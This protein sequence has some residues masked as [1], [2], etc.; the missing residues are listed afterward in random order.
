[1]FGTQVNQII[2]ARKKNADANDLFFQVKRTGK[3]EEMAEAFKRV[4]DFDPSW[5]TAQYHYGI[6]LIRLAKHKEALDNFQVCATAH[7]KW[8]AA[9]YHL[10]LCHLKTGNAL[11]AMPIFKS[12]LDLDFRDDIE[13]YSKNFETLGDQYFIMARAEKNKALRDNVILELKSICESEIK[14]NGK[15][16]WSLLYI[17]AIEFYFGKISDSLQTF[18]LASDIADHMAMNQPLMFRTAYG[19]YSIK[20]LSS[21]T[22]ILEGSPRVPAP[23]ITLN[24]AAPRDLVFLIGCDDGYFNRF[25]SSFLGTLYET[26]DNITVHF[27]I[28]GDESS[29]R[30]QR[31]LLA[32]TLR[33]DRKISIE[34]SFEAKPAHG[35]KTYYAL[36]RFVIASQIMNHYQCD[37]IIGDID[38][39]VIGDLHLVKSHVGDSDVGV[40]KNSDPEAFRKFPWNAIS[41]CYL[42]I[43][44]TPKGLDYARVISLLMLETFNPS[45]PKTWWLD[46]S[47][48]YCAT[49]YMENLSFGFK[50]KSL[51][52][53]K[54]PKPFMYSIPGKSKDDF[55]KSLVTMISSGEF[56]KKY[57]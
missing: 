48:L 16:P 20:S 36:S 9:V 6:A 25:S 41:G 34:F 2:E 27:H 51:I 52:G 8:I 22:A 29:I 39:A 28:I 23:V 1:M 11:M 17:A 4:V 32:S 56:Q 45:S 35:N 53:N 40:D 18:E 38:A 33:K 49:Y 13:E 42:Y 3:K 37:L 31:D 57:A 10:G 7:P 5:T 30:V 46:Q 47:V 54:A 26:N 14:K 24:K 12:I 19:C 21:M 50:A 44:N 15:Q 55:S 43:R